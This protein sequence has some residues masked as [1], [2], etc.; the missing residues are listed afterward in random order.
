MDYHHFKIHL[1]DN[2]ERTFCGRKVNYPSL[3]KGVLPV[4]EIKPLGLGKP[5][6]WNLWY[7]A[8]PDIEKMRQDENWCRSCL[9]ILEGQAVPKNC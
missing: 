1:A 5:G 4:E 2:T 9:R 6:N 7:P 3:T 8:E